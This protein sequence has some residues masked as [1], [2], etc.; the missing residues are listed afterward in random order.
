MNLPRPIAFACLCLSLLLP[1]HEAMAYT[2]YGASGQ[3][4]F[5]DSMSRTYN[6]PMSAMIGTWM[7]NDL[8]NMSMRSKLSRMAQ[9]QQAKARAPQAAPVARK[10]D[11]RATDATGPEQNLLS[12]FLKEAQG[13]SN[14]E[15]NALHTALRAGITATEKELPRKRNLAWAMAGVIGVAMLVGKGQEMPEDNVR[16]LAEGMNEILAGAPE[17]QQAPAAQKQTLYEA[18]LLTV[19]LM[20]METQSPD[21]A[22]RQVA[23]DT[24]LGILASFGVK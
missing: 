14:D 22:T 1:A 4:M 10:V 19:A 21:K 11:F 17:W 2:T 16:R 20:V 5:K 23:K 7:N 8:M 24:A 12:R 3:L 13:L 6:N 9:E 15:R 18:M